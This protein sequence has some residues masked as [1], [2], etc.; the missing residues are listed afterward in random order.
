MIHKISGNI[1]LGL[2]AGMLSLSQLQ[3]QEYYDVGNGGYP[4]YEGYQGYQDY[5]DY[6]GY[7]GDCCYSCEPCGC[8]RFWVDA[9]YLY[10]KIQDCPESVPLVVEGSTVSPILGSSGTK[11][12]LGGKKINT[13]WRSG[14]K[15]TLGY[16]FDDERCF[17]VEANYF[18]LPYLSKKHSVFSSGEP[19][20]GFLGV[21]YFNV[22]TGAEASYALSNSNAA[23]QGGAWSGLGALRL[24]N[25]MQGAEL[26]ALFTLLND[27]CSCYQVGLLAGFRY[28]NFDERVTFFTSSPYL[29]HAGNVFQTKDKFEVEN[30]FYGG[31]IGIEFDYACNCFF[32]NIK[33]KVA[34][35]ANCSSVDIDG[36]FLTNDFNTTSFVGTPQAVVGGLFALPTN[37]GHHHKTYFSVLPEVSVNVG[38]K[39]WEC[40]RLQVGYSFLY[41]SNVLRAGKQI[42]RHINP[43]Q[44]GAI[45]YTTTPV[46]VGKAAPKACHK[47][48]GIWAQGLNAGLV[49]SF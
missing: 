9:E 1:F 25:R 49:F 48:Q 6:Q 7:D 15:I 4:G 35:G 17:G 31:Q 42:N 11:V 29:A 27:C 16:W 36:R 2:V 32:F 24:Q 47:T 8:D 20:T 39:L 44:S 13:N 37:I 43:T 26:N 19:G 41:A 28:W 18:L 23:I 21:P 38:Y 30:N 45:E 33:G 10:W 12:V 46:L 14:G 5:E 34:L 40:L 22:T 3:A